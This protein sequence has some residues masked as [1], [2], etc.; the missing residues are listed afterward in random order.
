[1]CSIKISQWPCVYTSNF[2]KYFVKSCVPFYICILTSDIFIYTKLASKRFHYS[3]HALIFWLPYLSTLGNFLLIS[4]FS[5]V[6]TDCKCNQ[7]IIN[8][9]VKVNSAIHWGLNCINF[10][11]GLV[12]CGVVIKAYWRIF[13]SAFFVLFVCFRNF[14]SS[15]WCIFVKLT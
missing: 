9:K 7:S 5:A 14:L 8:L 1:M 6:L 2:T 13:L 4:E 10:I 11:F 12:W 15:S 3:A